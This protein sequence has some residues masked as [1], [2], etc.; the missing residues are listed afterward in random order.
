MRS[1]AA[2]FSPIM[3]HDIATA[4]AELQAL[5]TKTEIR[6]SQLRALPQATLQ[7]H[8]ANGGWSALEC[9]EHLNRYAAYYMP[10]IEKA[11]KAAPRKSSSVYHSGWLG[12]YFANLMRAEKAK[13]GKMSSPKDKNPS[14]TTLNAA[15]VLKDFTQNLS[16]IRTLLNDALQ[17][18]WGGIR[19]PTS[20]SPLVRL[21]LGDTLRFYVFHIDRHM[22]QATRA[23]GL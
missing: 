4:A 12:E 17:A 23:V 5:L 2:N 8:P 9:L 10:A 11:I 7:Q 6:L 3:K 18:D 1:F 14:G 15:T 13:P 16:R 22:A 19:I 21:K 20:L